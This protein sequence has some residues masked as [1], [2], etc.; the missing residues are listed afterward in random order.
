MNRALISYGLTLA[1]REYG[2]KEVRRAVSAIW[3]T[4]HGERLTKK[5]KEAAEL[6]EGLPYSNAIAFLEG[7]L[8]RYQ[9]ITPDFLEAATV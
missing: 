6:V 8:E 7:E 1:V 4:D 9:L 3:N 5:L 2:A